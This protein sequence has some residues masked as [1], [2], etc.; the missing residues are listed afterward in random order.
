MKQR[1]NARFLAVGIA[2][3]RGLGLATTFA[4]GGGGRHLASVVSPEEP[5]GSIE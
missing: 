5:T 2:V 3:A 4:L 1:R